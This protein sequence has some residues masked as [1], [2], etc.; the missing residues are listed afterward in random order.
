MKLGK[1]DMSKHRGVS[2]VVETME[3]IMR[4]KYWII[5]IVLLLFL[6]GCKKNTE[7]TVDLQEIE[8]TETVTDSEDS[9]YVYVCGAVMEEGVYELPSGSRVYEAIL[10]AGG[11]AEDAAV[12]EVNQAAVLED[13]AKLYVPT[14]TELAFE[15]SKQDGKVNLN[16]ATKESLMTLPGVGESKA[17]LIIQ[18]REEHG[19][20]QK[21]E[22]I[23]NISGIKEGLFEKIKN[24]IKI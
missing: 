5:L 2:F 20:F 24:Y 17:E 18:Y 10:E 21:I 9:I 4:R 22:D 12:A 23:M 7:E 19:G 11:F 15:Q 3:E 14:L 16:T 1:M 13:E 8:T 6:A